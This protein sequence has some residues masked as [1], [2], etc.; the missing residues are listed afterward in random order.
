MVDIFVFK[1]NLELFEDPW[2]DDP[3]VSSNDE[4]EE[5]EEESVDVEDMPQEVQAC[6]CG[7]CK[8]DCD[9][10]PK[11]CNNH[12]CIGQQD[13]GKVPYYSIMG[14]HGD[15]E[16][17]LFH[18]LCSLLSLF[19]SSVSDSHNFQCVSGSSIFCQCA[20]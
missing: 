8:E 4:K 19:S 9:I 5:E 14:S 15:Y 17:Y 3:E 12:L 13:T 2:R 10:P 16:F 20:S 7:Y 11:C 1:S 6:T 18:N